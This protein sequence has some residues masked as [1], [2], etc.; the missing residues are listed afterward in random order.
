MNAREAAEWA[1]FQAG[2]LSQ[3]KCP[4][5]GEPEDGGDFGWFTDESGTTYCNNCGNEV[6]HC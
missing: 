2:M 4:S 1:D 6:E 3:R 5:C